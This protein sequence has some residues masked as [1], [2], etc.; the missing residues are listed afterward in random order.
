MAG[1]EQRHG[2]ARQGRAHGAGR[3]G[4]ADALGEFAVRAGLPA[5]DGDDLA[6][7]ALLEGRERGEVDIDDAGAALDGGA[8]GLAQPIGQPGLGLGGRPCRSPRAEAN[9][10][11]VWVRLDESTVSPR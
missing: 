4:R 7:D 2:V 9:W 8:D 1:D 5:R 6:Q 10:A 3:T 11:G